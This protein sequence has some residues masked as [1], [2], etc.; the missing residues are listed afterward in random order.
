MTGGPTTASRPP[1][2]P[3]AKEVRAHSA[4][5]KSETTPE[6]AEGSAARA[7]GP[8]ADIRYKGGQGAD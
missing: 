8:V 1:G 7:S 2:R 5:T 3:G 4:P 6:L